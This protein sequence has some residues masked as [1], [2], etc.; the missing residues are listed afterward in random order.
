MFLRFAYMTSSTAAGRLPRDSALRIG[1]ALGMT[2][3]FW[4]NLQQMYDLELARAKTDTSAIE[5]LV[6]VSA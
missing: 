1:K 2:P 6:N 4:L 3:D 5:P